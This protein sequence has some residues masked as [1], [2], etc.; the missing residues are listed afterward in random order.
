MIKN[1]ILLIKAKIADKKK[2]LK[3][4]ELKADNCII[5]IRNLIDPYVEDFT[6]LKIENARTAMEDLY[7]LYLEAKT[8]KEQIKRL[9]S[10]IDG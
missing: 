5:T 10:E 4:L 8:L 7:K 9:E 2:C 6:T 3:E 1:E